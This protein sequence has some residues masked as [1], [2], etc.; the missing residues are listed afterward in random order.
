METGEDKEGFLEALHAY[1]VYAAHV[2]VY[3]EIHPYL[4]RI[5]TLLPSQGGEWLFKFVTGQVQARL[6]GLEQKK[7]TEEDP[8]DFLT[9]VLQLRD[10]DP[11]NFDMRNVFDTCLTNIGAG[12]DTTSVSLTGI[13]YN[14]IQAPEKMAKVCPDLSNSLAC[15]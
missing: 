2:G 15:H 5:I 12:S 13:L 4:H 1:L 14:L 11:E 7:K 9:R 6:A 8:D 3:S 10:R